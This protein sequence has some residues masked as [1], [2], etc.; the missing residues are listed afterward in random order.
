MFTLFLSPFLK[1]YTD[2][3]HLG[4]HRGSI[5]CGLLV[6]GVI[7]DRRVDVTEGRAVHLAMWHITLPRARR[8]NR[9]IIN[10]H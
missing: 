9:I 1:R 5:M 7:R 2:G 4:G 3:L 8:D 6:G 10:L